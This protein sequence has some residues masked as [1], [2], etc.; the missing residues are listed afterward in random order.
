MYAKPYQFCHMPTLTELAAQHLDIALTPAQSDSFAR[1]AALLREW[2]ARMNLTAITDE[3]EINIRHFLDSLTILKTNALPVGAKVIDVGTGAGFPGIPLAIVQPELRMTLLEATGKKVT[4]LE[5]VIAELG[6]VHTNAVK[7]RAEEAGQARA[8]RGIYD[9]AVARAVARL[10]ILLEYLL[11]LVRVGGVCI[12]MKG[13]TAQTEADDSAHALKTL[14]GELDRIE[15]FALPGVDEPH[16]LVIV[17]KVAYTPTRYPRSA[18]MPT[19]KP[20]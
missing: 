2:N 11:P 1:Y 13:R 12:A 20:L 6:L 18:G 19:Q 4:F 15:T 17:R 3:D 7:L 9:G 16:H 8:H 5:H 10:P 14:G